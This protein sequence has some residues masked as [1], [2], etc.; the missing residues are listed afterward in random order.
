MSVSYKSNKGIRLTQLSKQYFVPPTGQKVGGQK[1][2]FLL[3][4]LAKCPPHFQNRGAAPGG[5]SADVIDGAEAVI[6]FT[7]I[8]VYFSWSYH[9]II[10]KSTKNEDCRKIFTKG[11]YKLAFEHT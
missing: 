1:K 9:L 3:A 6:S 2:N 11:L 10:S 7:L 4:P 8:L 5:D